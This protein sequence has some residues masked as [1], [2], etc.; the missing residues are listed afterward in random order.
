MSLKQHDRQ[1]DL[2]VFG[3]TG[4]TGKYTAQ[5]ITTNLPTN[6]RWAI[7]GRSQ[8][9]LEAVAAECAKLN[10]DR[11][12]PAIEVVGNQTDP[13]GYAEELA[14]LARKTLVIITTVGPYGRLG[15]PAFRA[16]AENGTHYLDVTGEVPFVARMIRKYEATAKSTGA[17]MF[18][19]IGIESAPP[20]LITWSLASFIRSTYSSPIADV[21]LSIYKLHAAPS[22]GTISSALSLLENFSL[23]EVRS[24]YA[25]YALSPIPPSPHQQFH[26]PK[27]SLLTRL[28]GVVTIP[29]LGLQTTSMA[30]GTDAAYIQRTWGLLSS[31]PSRSQQSYGPKFTFREYMRPRGGSWF[32]GV[33]THLFLMFLG[34]VMATPFLRSL[35]KKL[36][37]TQPG[38]GPA[39]EVAKGDVLEYR[40]VATRD[41][42][43]GETVLSRAAWK[44]SA[45]YFTG[46]L[47]AEAAAT[48][49]QEDL[50]LPGGVYTAACLGQPFIDRLERAGFRIETWR[51]E[52][53]G[54]GNN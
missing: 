20:D 23:S 44:G 6:L 3:A 15:E 29:H 21:V 22:G 2:V 28:T 34:V 14:G 43:S 24:A 40:A 16:C 26:P 36:V 17:L 48:I 18:P 12:P 7:A 4:Y 31:L 39:D 10:P 45:Y 11:L 47:A 41:G 30:G 25:P 42:G 13:D 53:K 8:P 54:W 52:E 38:E 51:A 37:G 5:Y 1:Y 19:Q 9:K 46:V 33:T 49:L 27:P 35:A 32:S 50:N